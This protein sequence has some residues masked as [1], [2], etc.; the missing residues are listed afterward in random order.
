MAPVSSKNATNV[1][2]VY[3]LV[4]NGTVRKSAPPNS[5]RRRRYFETSSREMYFEAILQRTV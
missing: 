3:L 1:I 2:A 4:Q 5:A